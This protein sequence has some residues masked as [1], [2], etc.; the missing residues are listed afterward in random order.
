MFII[1]VSVWLIVYLPPYEKLTY[2]KSEAC[3]YSEVEKEAY[4]FEGYKGGE[5]IPV[6]DAEDKEV[7]IRDDHS[8]FF[9]LKINAA[10]LSPMGIY[11]PAANDAAYTAYE[12]NALKVMILRTNEDYA[13]YYM[14]T[15]ANGEEIP[16][17]INE[18]A[19]KI[20]SSGEIILPIGRI[21]T[22]SNL[23][24]F[25]QNMV[26]EKYINAATGFANSNDMKKLHNARTMFAVGLMIAAF[27]GVIIWMVT[28]Q[29]HR[30]R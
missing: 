3:G 23:K 4:G 16:V 14:A 8:D 21:R 18:R 29:V 26:D 15:F 19:I 17:L 24:K 13:Q 12:T 28:V 11:R 27:I 20:P 5:D 2:S 6:F 1:L 30:R 9:R 10:D 22:D 7:S 25:D